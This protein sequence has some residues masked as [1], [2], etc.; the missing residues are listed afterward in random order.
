MSEMYRAVVYYAL[1]EATTT[2]VRM[3]SEWCQ[4]KERAETILE[5]FRPHENEW[6]SW[7]KGEIEVKR[8]DSSTFDG[9]DNE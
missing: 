2:T 8:V 3:T 5:E 9:G 4:T 7:F 6:G 1:D